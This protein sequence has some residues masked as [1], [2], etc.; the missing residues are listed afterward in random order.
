[1]FVNNNNNNETCQCRR[2]F[3]GLLRHTL[4][5]RRRRSGEVDL[6]LSYVNGAANPNG[7]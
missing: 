4:A 5:V 6:T 2:R 7:S 1:M 3:S